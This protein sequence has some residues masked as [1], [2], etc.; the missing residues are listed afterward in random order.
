MKR[1]YDL[2][3]VMLYISFIALVAASLM[4]Y[5]ELRAYGTYPWWNPAPSGGGAAPATS[6]VPAAIQPVWAVVSGALARSL[7]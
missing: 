3:T 5:M 7:A 1:N 4:L 6:A 2:Y